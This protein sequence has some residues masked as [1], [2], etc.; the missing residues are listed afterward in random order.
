[1]TRMLASVTGPEEAELVLA[2]GVD[3]V[4]LKDPA[5]GGFGAVDT[6]VVRRTVAAVAGRS[7]VS[8]VTGDL[9][10][11]PRLLCDAVATIAATGVDYVK[12]GICP[13][14]D[15]RGAIRALAPLAAQTRLVAVQF[16]DRAPDPALPA[17]AADAGFAGA[18]LD[19]AD[20]SAGRLLDHMDLPGLRRFVDTCSG[21]GL[22]SGLAGSLEPPDI[23][24][25]LLL[26]PGLLGFRGALCGAGGRAG[27][28]ITEAVRQVRA[29]IPADVEATEGAGFDYRVLAARGY[30]PDPDTAGTTADAVFVHDLVLPVR[31]GAYARERTAPQRVRF[32]VDVAV[33]RLDHPSADMRDVFSYDIISD[34]IRLLI[35]A[36]HIAFVETLAEQIA[37]LLLSY[38][39]VVRVSVQLTK[40]DAGPRAV[41]VRIE[42]TRG[43]P[44]AQR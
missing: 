2:A 18:M 14:G 42:R 7:L 16:A 15:A 10:L 28:I 38:R 3:I 5:R 43:C 41:G 44:A 32:D 24:R 30:V 27:G 23:P 40:L 37:A 17:V 13:D 1:M 19:T 11:D 34:G 36:G 33:A 31:I 8:A 12:L 25:L 21:L 9:P 4:D 39:R 6:E 29:L 26:N 22:L 35:D 20:K